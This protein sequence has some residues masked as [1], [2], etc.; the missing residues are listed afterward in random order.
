MIL[1]TV[2][3]WYNY[4]IREWSL[5]TNTAGGGVNQ[6]LSASKL[7][8]GKICVQPLKKTLFLQFQCT[9]FRCADLVPVNNDRS[10]TNMS[11]VQ[12]PIY[13]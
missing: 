8:G 4:D 1:E 3:D 5:F 10:L 2:R 13:F 7:K 9:D 12:R 11:Y 6:N